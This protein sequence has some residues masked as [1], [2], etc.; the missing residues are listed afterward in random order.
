MS[1][2]K[3]RILFLIPTLTGGGA[4]RVV[5]TLLRHLDR[6]CFDL[7]L[8]VVNTRD[9]V[10][11]SEVPVD[12]K[13]ID[14]CCDRVRHALPK[15]VRLV[16]RLRPDVVMSTLGHLNLAL[17]IIRPILPARTRYVARETAVVS[18]NI[19]GYARPAWWAW[20]YRRFYGRFDLVICQSLDMRADL[21]GRFGIDPRRTVV[22]NNPVDLEHIERSLKQG[23]DL[24]LPSYVDDASKLGAVQAVAVGRLV[25]QK[26]FDILVEALALTR[27]DV[28]LTVL[29]EGPLQTALEALVATRGLAKR[30]RFVGF[31]RNP[32]VCIAR[33]DVFVL[34]SRYEGFPNVVLESLACGTPVV[35][36]PAPGGVKEI[37]SA[38]EGCVI[39][40]GM[41]A[42]DLADALD[43][44]A[45]SRIPREA[46]D[47]YALDE[48]VGRYAEELGKP[49]E[50]QGG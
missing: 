24:T 35:A 37:L 33:A 10:F 36:L 34:S 12:V 29:G 47:R 22:I 9:A 6:D 20:A 18:H 11:R 41:S 17:S 40:K 1:P 50:A 46:L 21:V 39:A 32:Y 48:I 15:I 31:Q 5:V 8:A 3:R 28:N 25:E 44:W 13:F 7:T 4:E 14:L 43:R 38:V 19:A 27:R 16:W 23:A 2:A 49:L 45:P 26:G 42:Q 30:V